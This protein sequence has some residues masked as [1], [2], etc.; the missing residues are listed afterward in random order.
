M[1]YFVSIAKTGIYFFMLGLNTN[2]GDNARMKL[3]YSY[4]IMLTDITRATSGSH[5]LT[6]I[7]ELGEVHLFGN[8]SRNS[9]GNFRNNSM[10]RAL[11]SSPF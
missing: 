10:P 1:Q 11:E 4:D 6:L 5:E 2:F 3:V 9:F 8:S 7:F